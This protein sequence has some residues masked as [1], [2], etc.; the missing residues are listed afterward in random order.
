MIQTGFGYVGL[1]FPAALVKVV[2]IAIVGLFIWK[3]GSTLGKV[4]FFI[5]IFILVAF[6]ASLISSD[7]PALLH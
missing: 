6:L 1:Q 2:S 3:V 5:A 7:I 4:V